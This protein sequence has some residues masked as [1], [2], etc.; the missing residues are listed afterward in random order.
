MFDDAWM[1]ISN[2]V[3]M[4]LGLNGENEAAQKI[5]PMQLTMMNV[6]P[7]KDYH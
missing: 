2:K 1:I 3:A 6:Y 4:F 7:H 5:F